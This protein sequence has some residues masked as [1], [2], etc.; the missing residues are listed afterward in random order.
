MEK[1][2]SNPVHTFLRVGPIEHNRTFFLVAS[3]G[4]VC[5]PTEDPWKLVVKG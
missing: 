2:G 5:R 3:M 1:A 4:W